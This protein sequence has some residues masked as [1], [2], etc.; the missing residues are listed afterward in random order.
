MYEVARLASL[1]SRGRSI[2]LLYRASRWTH[3][4]DSAIEDNWINRMGEEEQEWIVAD[5][6][7]PFNSTNGCETF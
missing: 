7:T 4:A 6:Y 5:T 3:G 1:V 2:Y